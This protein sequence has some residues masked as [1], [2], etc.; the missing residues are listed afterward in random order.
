VNV[1]VAMSSGD[2]I[3]ADNGLFPLVALLTSDA[4]EA[5]AQ[6]NN[7]AFADLLAPFCAT[8]ISIK[9][10]TGVQISTKLRIDLRD[11]QKSG[12]LLSLTVL[13]SVLHEA[14]LSASSET[15]ENEDIWTSAFRD[16]F[17]YWFEPSEVDFLKSY[18]CCMFVIS[19][20]DANPLGEL[21]RLTQLQHLQQHGSSATSSFG[22]AHC[23][24][25]KWFLPNILKF[26]VIL[27]DVSLG[28]EQK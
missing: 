18:L 23:T 16:T 25:P 12:Y 2:D 27:Q 8:S 28:N 15:K 11:V 6:K 14:I 20:E 17:M 9:D 13:P 1:L 7:L 4:V 22:P 10:P 5:A 24:A 26:Y 3:V 21:N 19:A